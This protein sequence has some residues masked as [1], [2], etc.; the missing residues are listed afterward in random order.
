MTEKRSEGARMNPARFAVHWRRG[1]AMAYECMGPSCGCHTRKMEEQ[2]REP[3]SRAE[4]NLRYGHQPTCC[5][6]TNSG[7]C[8][9]GKGFGERT[10]G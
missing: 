2:L 7:M 10:N 9:C 6:A 5:F 1:S 8:D 4:F 3:E